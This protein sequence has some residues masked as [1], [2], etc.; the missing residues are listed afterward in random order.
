VVQ[1]CQPLSL[2]NVRFDLDQMC[3]FVDVEDKEQNR[4]FL[5]DIW[6]RFGWPAPTAVAESA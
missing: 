6:L 5:A 1:A 3:V 4:P 2:R